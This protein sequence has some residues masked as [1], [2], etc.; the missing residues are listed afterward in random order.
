VTKVTK[1]AYEYGQ[2]WSRKLPRRDIKWL[3]GNMHCST[4]YE[5]VKAEIR[6]HAEETKNFPRRLIPQ[7]ERYAEAVHRAQR[8]VY[9]LF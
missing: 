9:N 2:R 4:S 8:A 3:L 7:C 6:R 5:E 1:Y